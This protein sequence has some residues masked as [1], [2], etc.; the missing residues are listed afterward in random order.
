MFGGTLDPYQ[1]IARD[2]TLHALRNARGRGALLALDTGLGKSIVTL[3]VADCLRT[4]DDICGRLGYRPYRIIVVASPTVSL[5]WR[6]EMDK[7][8]TG[9]FLFFTHRAS[10]QLDRLKHALATSPRDVLVQM[11]VV[12]YDLLS[13]PLLSAFPP[14]VCVFDECHA[15]KNPDSVRHRKAAQVPQGTYKIGLSGTPNTNN[16]ERD[17]RSLLSILVG[18]VPDPAQV[19]TYVIRVHPSEA[20]VGVSF[21]GTNSHEHNAAFHTRFESDVYDDCYRR[22]SA[23]SGMLMAQRSSSAAIQDPGILRAY[24]GAI[25]VLS[26]AANHPQL[27]EVRAKKLK[28]KHTV[29][30]TKVSTVLDIL[31]RH[32]NRH[33]IIS[34][35]SVQMI[36]I[37]RYHLR[38]HLRRRPIF[39]FTGE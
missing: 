26:L 38:R 2:R 14:D 16:P 13:H 23:L 10:S 30:S 12:S 20:D 6:E 27:S 31:R 1:E 4:R 37:L 17:M 35:R 21:P 3:S 22:V 18:F 11:V 32:P 8:M 19:P 24:Q 7:H 9:D 5:V 34:T 36:H 39:V 28:P 15:L 29:M 25:N 33:P